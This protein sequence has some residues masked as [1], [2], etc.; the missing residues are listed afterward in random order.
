[1][2]DKEIEQSLNNQVNQEFNSAQVYL[3]MSAYLGHQN[4]PGFS[5]W[6][7]VQY[8]EEMLHALK[9]F[10]YIIDRGGRVLLQSISA[11]RTEWN[12][13]TDVFK[14]A[15]EHENVISSKIYQ[16]V[17]LA[18][19]KRDHATNNFLQWFVAEQVEEESK[20]LAIC[21]QLQMI[22]GSKSSL[23]LLDKEYGARTLSTNS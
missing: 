11:P 7:N 23:F 19:S 8:Q 13:P 6:M 4:L 10:H 16:L 2:L 3:S 22:E 15:A 1:M 20:S 9:I 17:D 14:E 5:K 18:I 21:H 12:N